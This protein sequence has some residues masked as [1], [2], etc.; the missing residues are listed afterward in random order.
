MGNVEPEYGMSCV[1]CAALSCAKGNGEYPAFCPTARMSEEEVG[2]SA[3]A[4]REDEFALRVM[5]EA[6]ATGTRA[7]SE[8][9]CRAEEIMDFARRMGYRRIGIAT[10]SGL[11]DYARL[12]AKVLRIHGFDV[13]GV[14]CK[15]GSIPRAKLEAVESCC[16][17]GTVSCN[18]LLQV[19]KLNEAKTDLNVVIGLCV[20]HDTLFYQRSDAPCTTLVTKDRVLANNA[21]AVFQVLNSPSPYSRMLKEDE[22]FSPLGE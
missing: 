19:E 15:V 17:F 14:A 6:S 2:Q 13:F 10:C 22:S 20:G 4:Y 21:G 1:D 12:Y 16:D 8:H 7:F 18:P 3:N 9:L 11:A 5:R